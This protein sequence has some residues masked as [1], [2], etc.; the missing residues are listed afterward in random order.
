[1]R[2]RQHQIR[3][4]QRSGAKVSAAKIQPADGLPA[5]AFVSGDQRLQGRAFASAR[6]LTHQR[7]GRRNDTNCPHP[8]LF[9][10]EK[11]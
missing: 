3:R 7:Q 11:T 9:V 1:M 5:F 4:N 8:V 10:D 6:R 2:R